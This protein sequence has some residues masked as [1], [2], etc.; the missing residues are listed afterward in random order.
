MNETA[1]QLNCEPLP[2]NLAADYLR[3]RGETVADWEGICGE[4]ADDVLRSATGERFMLYVEGEI[5]WR[6][7]MA[8]LVG[9]F[10]HDAWCDGPA[11]PIARWLSKMFGGG[12]VVLSL[13]GDDIYEGPADRFE[14][15]GADDYRITR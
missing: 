1:K 2:T 6:H 12:W 15:R 13:D 10:V 14:G 7:H 9:G 11:L 4:L 3:R 8:P 5:G